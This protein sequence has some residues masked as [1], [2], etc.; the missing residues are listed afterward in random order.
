MNNFKHIFIA[1]VVLSVIISGSCQSPEKRDNLTQVSID[2]DKWLINGEITNPGSPAAGLLMNVRM[3]NAVFED[4]GN[5]WKKQVDAFDPDEN[6]QTFINHIPEYVELGV[7]AFVISLQGGLPGYEGAINTAFE[8]DGKLRNS[9]LD[10]VAKVIREADKHDAAIILSCFYQR[11][12][13]HEYALGNKQAIIEAVRNTANWIAEEGFTNVVLEIANEYPHGGY[14]GWPDSDWLVS[15]GGQV[16]LMKAAKAVHPNLLVSTSGLG[17]G[18][19]PEELVSVADFLLI[20]FN[21]TALEDYAEKINPLKKYGKPI[22][23]NEDDK[24]G[25]EGAAALAYSVLHGA[26][27]G[28]ME[29]GVNQHIPFEF[30]GES[31]DPEVYNMFKSMSTPG[32]QLDR[33]ML[34]Q[35]SVTIVY[36]NDGNVFKEGNPLTI[37]FSH[38]FQ[39]TT[40]I[41]KLVLM[42]N[43]KQIPLENNRKSLEW[44]PEAAGAYYLRI[45]VY[46]EQGEVMYQSAPV[47]IEVSPLTE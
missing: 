20:H 28:F 36:P 11:Q 17:H 5:G 35:A 6:T 13:D 7:N 27:W 43:D 44:K 46:D 34:E 39:D 38:L 21:N 41:S 9:Y 24:I 23:C 3:V 2:G 26:G 29:S 40:T 45:V 25:K 30:K 33:A 16:E 15:E 18:R 42:A 8:P 10:R 4:R 31:D 1:V 37:K 12:R 14:K 22:V 32:Y 47:D 19:F